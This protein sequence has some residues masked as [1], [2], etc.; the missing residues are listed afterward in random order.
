MM[1]QTLERLFE[2]KLPS[3]P[4]EVRLVVTHVLMGGPIH[5]I[6]SMFSKTTSV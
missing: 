2:Q 4:K 5:L 1:C 3:M 6:S